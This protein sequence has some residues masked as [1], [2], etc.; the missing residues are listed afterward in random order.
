MLKRFSHYKLIDGTIEIDGIRMHQTSRKTPL[1]D[2]RDKISLIKLKP[3]Y[4]A[5]DICTGLGY[6]A[7]LLAKKTK[8]V[9]TID[10]DM[11]VIRTAKQNKDSALLFKLENI[12]KVIAFA[13]E[14]IQG[15]PSDFFD[16][17]YHDPP[18]ISRAGELYSQ[19]F[20]SELYRI[21]KKNR[22]L[23]HYTG[24]PGSKRGKNIPAGVKKRLAIAGFKNITWVDSVLGF[25]AQK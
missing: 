23:F 7:I 19:N 6:N 5:L 16:V 9:I 15:F 13:E 21:L 22:K 24:T 17:I 25:V 20:Y 3:Y 8:Y 14:L 12:F 1:Q 18:R 10:N 4:K 11:H 2:A